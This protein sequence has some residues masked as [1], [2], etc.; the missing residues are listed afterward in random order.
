MSQILRSVLYQ[1]VTSDRG[2]GLEGYMRVTEK[3][4]PSEVR[5]HLYSS[6]LKKRICILLLQTVGL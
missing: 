4:Y 5:F 3:I 6:T 2:I 1:T